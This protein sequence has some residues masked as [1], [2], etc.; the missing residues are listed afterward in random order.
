MGFGTLSFSFAETLDAWNASVALPKTGSR[1]GFGTLSFSFAETLD[2]WN[3]SVTL[4]NTN[5]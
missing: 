4:P 2:A 3:A 1:M 5:V